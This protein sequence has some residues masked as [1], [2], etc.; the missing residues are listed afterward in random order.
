MNTLLAMLNVFID[1]AETVRRIEGNRM[2][3]LWPILVGGLLMGIYQWNSAHITFE[4]LRHDPPA[5]MDPAAFEKA[6]SAMQMTSRFAAIT[7]PVMWAMMAMI[8]SVLL[9][10]ACVITSTNVQFPMVFCLVAHTSLIK[11]VQMIAHLLVLKGKG[12]ITSMKELLPSFGLE[13]FLAEDTNRILYGMV[14]F[15]SIFQVWHMV[16]LAVGFAAL[17]KCGKGRAFGI[18]APDWVLGLFFAIVGSLFVRR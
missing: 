2:S 11:A 10:A 4:V 14:S 6:G 15:F 3:W 1:P 16:V 18:T 5:G 13:M 17:A 12:E 7:A 8:T 9:Y